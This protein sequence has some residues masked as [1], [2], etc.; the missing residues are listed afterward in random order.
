[1]GV[2]LRKEKYPDIAM[3]IVSKE[4][5]C[6]IQ[7][8]KMIGLIWNCRGVSKKIGTKVKD[9]YTEFKADFIGLQE[10][11]GKSYTD[12]FFRGIDPHNSF[13]WH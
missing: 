10:T 4:G 11:I 1:M 5:K 13:A 9:L 6:Q 3:D 7:I 2:T 8:F 12:K